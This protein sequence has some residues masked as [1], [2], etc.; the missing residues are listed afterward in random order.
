MTKSI[1]VTILEKDEEKG[2]ALFEAIHRYGLGVNGHF[3][4]HDLEKMQ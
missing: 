4:V 2:R 1:W 3:W